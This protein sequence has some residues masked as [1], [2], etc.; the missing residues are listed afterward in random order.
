M[1]KEPKKLFEDWKKK[2]VFHLT[3]LCDMTGLYGPDIL[4]MCSR[5]FEAGLNICTCDNCIRHNPSQQF[6]VEEYYE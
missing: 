1:N 6:D 4:E 2:Q 5:A 3:Y